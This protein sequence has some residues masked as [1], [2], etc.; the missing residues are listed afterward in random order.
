MSIISQDA[1]FEEAL[2]YIVLLEERTRNLQEQLRRAEMRILQLEEDQRFRERLDANKH[3]SPTDKQV[4]LAVRDLVRSLQSE[5][6]CSTVI[7]MWQIAKMTGLGA[8][9]VQR[10]VAKLDDAGV[11]KRTQRKISEGRGKWRSEVAIELGLL[12]SE[13]EAMRLAQPRKHGGKREQCE[14]CGGEN[15]EIYEAY[16]CQDCGHIHHAELKKET[17]GLRGRIVREEASHEEL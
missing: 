7:P 6:T 9:T 15:L 17:K 13:P 3:L 11:W 10:S 14:K 5:E 1:D 8:R 12:S 4:F 16:I 2:S